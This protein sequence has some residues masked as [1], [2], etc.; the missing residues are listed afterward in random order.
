VPRDGYF[1]EPDQV[2]KFTLIASNFPCVSDCVDESTE[3]FEIS[4]NFLIQVKNDASSKWYPNL[5]LEWRVFTVEPDEMTLEHLTPGKYLSFELSAL[6]AGKDGLAPSRYLMALQEQWRERYP[7]AAIH[8]GKGYGYQNLPGYGSPEDAVQYQNDD[9][10]DS[11]YTRAVRE[12]FKQKMLQYDP[13]GTFA[14]GSFLRLLGM[15]TD[16]FTPKQYVGDQCLDFGNDDCISGCC[17][18]VFF[19]AINNV[20]LPTGKNA[21]ESCSETCECLP[22]LSC[23]WGAYP[24]QWSY[25]CRE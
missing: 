17:D 3:I 9:I 23:K 19:S 25:A 4:R 6:R 11:V 21:N 1:L 18:R 12:A 8:H 14:A 13:T 10:L 2:P 7:D 5:P 24:W 16:K 20:C 22:G 15:T